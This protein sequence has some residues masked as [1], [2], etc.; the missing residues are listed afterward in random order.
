MEW[1]IDGSEALI[2]GGKRMFVGAEEKVETRRGE[3][4]V[5]EDKELNKDEKKE[6]EKRTEKERNMLRVSLAI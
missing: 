6:K 3:D 5:K 4:G 2:S 1:K